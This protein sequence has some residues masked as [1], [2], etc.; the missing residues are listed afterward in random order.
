MTSRL[1]TLIDRNDV[2]EYAFV[3]AFGESV[4]LHAEKLLYVLAQR[5]GAETAAAFA[6]PRFDENRQHVMWF[7]P[8]SGDLKPFGELTDDQQDQF[9]DQLAEIRRQILSLTEET[10]ATAPQRGEATLYARMLPLL[11][12]FP[13]PVE[14]HLFQ[15][16]G[17]PVVINWGMNKG[18]GQNAADTVGPFID[19]WKQ[20]LEERRRQ[21]RLQAEAAAREASFIGRLTRAGAKSGAVTV[22]LL[23]NDINDLDLHVLCPNGE[24]IAFHNKQ[25][26]GGILDVDRNA[27]PCALTNS[28]VENIAWAQTPT[29]KGDYVVLVTFFRQHDPAQASSACTVRLLKNGKTRFFNATLTPRQTIEV[30]RFRI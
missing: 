4:T 22:S 14:Y 8:R 26:C 21:A 6:L 11:L 2:Q 28:P 29:L 25:A 1:V 19:A 16:G 9:L 5:R 18:A 15:L 13:K 12:N 7:G 10:A 30:T 3:G 20:R 17:R 27:H 24:Q 23:W